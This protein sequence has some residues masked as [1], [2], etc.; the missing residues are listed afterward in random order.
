MDTSFLQ[1]QNGSL[2]A[3]SNTKNQMNNFKIEW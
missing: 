3:R 2:S 1:L